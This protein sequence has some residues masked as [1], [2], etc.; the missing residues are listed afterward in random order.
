[1]RAGYSRG[2]AVIIVGAIDGLQ[3]ETSDLVDAVADWYTRDLARIPPGLAF[4]FI[5]RFNPDGLANG[6]RFNDRGVDLNRNW[7]TSDWIP[8]P[9]LPEAPWGK[10]GAGGSYPF[11]E[12]E[13]QALRD[14]ILALTEDSVEVLFVVLHASASR[15]R[16]ETYP[17]YTTAGDHETSNTLAQGV[18]LLTGYAYMPGWEEYKV[19]GEAIHWSAEQGLPSVEIVWPTGSPPDVSLLTRL[20]DMVAR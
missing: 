12:S 10:L 14:L 18:S 1:M 16:G 7:D 20:I 13:T 2:V 17:G 9:P 6:S 3:P 8:S 15:P 5:A 11:S 4:Y 19:P